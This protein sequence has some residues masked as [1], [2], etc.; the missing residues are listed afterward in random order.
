MITDDEWESSLDAPSVP[1]TEEAA[2]PTPEEIEAFAADARAA[3]VVVWEA[4]ARVAQ[5]NA[6]LAE[7]QRDAADAE[8]AA[9]TIDKRLLDA[10]GTDYAH[11]RYG[12]F[13]RKKSES[14]LGL[15]SAAFLAWASKTGRAREV[16]PT[17]KELAADGF[18]FLPNGRLR[19]AATKET[20]PE[21][22]K[23][24]GYRYEFAA[25]T[26]EEVEAATNPEGEP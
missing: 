14:T 19:N 18:K 20:V 3:W 8:V 22:E 23:F 1:N 26:D 13:V 15:A 7:V 10:A 6:M 21:V 24:W 5:V 9:R 12:R 16:P 17:L 11:P 25:A 4:K 2:G